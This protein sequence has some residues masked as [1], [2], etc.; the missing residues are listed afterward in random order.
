M[1]ST[2]AHNLESDPV[3]GGH[4]TESGPGW[5]EVETCPAAPTKCEHGIYIAAGDEIARYCGLCNPDQYNDAILYRTMKRHRAINRHFPEP[6]TLDAADF[7]EQNA[8]LRMDA[9]REFFEL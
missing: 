9:A 8:G 1:S 4:I 5:F 2:C 3:T 6:R 7:M